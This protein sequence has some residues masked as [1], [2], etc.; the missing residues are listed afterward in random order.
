MVSAC[1]VVPLRQSN[2]FLH[3][4]HFVTQPVMTCARLSVREYISGTTRPVFAL[5]L[6]VVVWLP[7]DGRCDASCILLLPFLWINVIFAQCRRFSLAIRMQM[8]CFRNP[9]IG[10]MS[11]CRYRLQ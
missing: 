7:S 2:F 10:G 4:T 5:L 8:Q 11:N 6:M 1:R 9:G 3:P